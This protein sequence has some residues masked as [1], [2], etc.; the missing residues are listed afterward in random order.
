M[1][2]VATVAECDPNDFIRK[3]VKA[4]YYAKHHGTAYLKCLSA[5]PLNWGDRPATERS[6]IQSAVDCCYFPLYEVE[7]GITALS[8]DPEKKNKKIPAIEWLAR[9]GRTKHLREPKYAE[10]VEK[11]Q[12][13]IDRR[14]KRLRAKADHPDL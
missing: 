13:E 14:W 5:C 7:R 9:M 8:Y 4:Q 2:Y 10:T 3:A 6:V 11:I 1:P 12:A